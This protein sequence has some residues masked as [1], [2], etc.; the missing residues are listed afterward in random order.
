[1]P[2]LNT[3]E[4]E[5]AT[6]GLA[7][8]FPQLTGLIELPERSVEGRTCHAL[9]I[10]AESLAPKD[11]V[12]L[13]GGVHA[14]E[15]GSCEILVHFAADLLEAYTSGTGL[16]YGGTSFSSDQVQRIL[17]ELDVVVFPLVNPD[18]RHYSQTVDPMWRKNRNPAN[19]G[20]DPERIGV[21]INRNYD[22]LFD[23]TTAFAPAAGPRTSA[24]PL[25]EVYE[26]PEPFSEPETR[27]VR[28]LLDEFPRT[29]WFVD[30]HSY[31]EDM[32]FVWGDD[33]NQSV[34]PLMNFRNPAFDGRRGVAGDLAYA[35]FIP[36][37]DADAAVLLAEQFC[38]GLQGV[39][40]RPYTPMSAFHLYPT[41]GTSD[42]YAFS[43]H[44]VDRDKG[45]ILAFTIEWGTSFHP[46]WAEMRNIVL[47][48]DAG[49]VQFCLSAA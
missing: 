13:I 1:M 34:Q 30:V 5:S 43:R 47:D 29:R 46:P 22:F 14:R 25:D 15:W 32:L 9:R 3:T 38:Q 24:D 17:N 4:V 7:A 35:E 11:D 28:W 37:T 31:S 36:K 26:G 44:L 41:S 23:F 27:N 40:G 18:G 16:A 42:D 21:D 10:G 33:E 19:S 2:Y 39:R 45:R 48:V 8:A 6:V 12:V 20:G 49:L